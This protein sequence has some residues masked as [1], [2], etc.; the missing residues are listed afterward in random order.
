MLD[1]DHEIL[2]ETNYIKD[3]RQNDG[4]KKLDKR[5]TIVPKNLTNRL[6]EEYSVNNEEVDK[7]NGIMPPPAKWHDCHTSPTSPKTGE[8]LVCYDVIYFQDSFPGIYR[9]IRL[10]KLIRMNIIN[11]EILVLGLRDL[12]SV[13]ILPVKKATCTFDF[14]N[15]LPVGSDII[16]ENITTEI[17][18]AGPNPSINTIIRQ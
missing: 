10:S 11:F 14:K 5:L 8:I 13:G 16:V 3:L 1:K 18:P 15:L 7:K 9:E 17:G 6:G 2:Y 4:G 12:Q